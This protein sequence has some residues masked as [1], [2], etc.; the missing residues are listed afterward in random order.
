MED[1]IDKPE[2]KEF[3][4]RI[5]SSRKLKRPRTSK[6]IRN[7]W[8]KNSRKTSTNFYK[9]SS[10]KNGMRMTFYKTDIKQVP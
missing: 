5:L 7:A 9:K 2:M 1:E 10:K 6:S 8:M 4:D 3:K